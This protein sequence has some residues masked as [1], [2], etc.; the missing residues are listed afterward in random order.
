[1]GQ[2]HNRVA[3]VTGAGG[4]LGREHALLLAAEGATVVVN[5]LHGAQ[6]VVDEI[7]SAGGEAVAVEG[8]VADMTTGE[9][10]VAA[11][12]ESF[13]D[14]HVIVNN[15]GVVRDAMLWNMTEDQFDLVVDVHLKGAFGLTRAAGR[16]WREQSRSGA[17]ADRSIVNTTSAAGLHGNVGQWNYAAAKAGLAIQ[18]VL[19]AEELGRFGVRANAISPAARTPMVTTAPI[20]AAAVAAPEDEDAFDRFHP[21]N[22]SSLVGYLA[23]ADCPFTG[24]VFSVTGGHVG[25]YA[26]YS[27]AHSVDTDRPWSV[28]ELAELMGAAS[29][30]K[31]A[32]A[33]RPRLIQLEGAGQ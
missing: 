12:V 3:V 4:G 32:E 29:F 18:A 6:A 13:G 22:V 28:D 27:L 1:M 24:Q 8:S 17:S 25:L 33:I 7:R 9:Q 20:L 11:A 23:T 30:P 2:L 21:R 14:L 10:L 15:A 16:F 19:A 26:G 5:D 31:S